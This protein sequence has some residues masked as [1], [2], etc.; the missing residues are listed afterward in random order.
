MRKVLFLIFFS[1]ITTIIFAKDKISIA[2]LMFN[3]NSYDGEN[4]EFLEKNI[5]EMLI[6]NLNNQ[7][8]SES[9]IY[10]LS[11]KISDIKNDWKINND[12]EAYENGALLKSRYIITGEISQKERGYEIVVSLYNATKDYKIV[13]IKE[14][15]M[16]DDVYTLVENAG[17]IVSKEIEDEIERYLS[18]RISIKQIISFDGFIGYPI[19]AGDYLSIQV[20]ALYFGTGVNFSYPIK[21]EKNY[22]ILIRGGLFYL[23]EF[24]FFNPKKVEGYFYE[25]NIGLP[26][27]VVFDIKNIISVITGLGFG[28]YINVYQQKDFFGGYKFYHTYGPGIFLTLNLEAPLKADRK[29]NLGVK[30][31]FDF[32]FYPGNNSEIKPKFQYKAGFYL[33][34]KMEV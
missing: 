3:V 15:I 34:Y 7:K 12:K 16:S 28:N 25:M 20:G 21:K 8:K 30:N 5:P 1:T 19:P 27:E 33:L 29:I 23:F 9:Y 17:I 24:L 6:N 22:K 4:L 31:N 2:L 10:N 13:S 18:E 11:W 14:A 32:I 26:F